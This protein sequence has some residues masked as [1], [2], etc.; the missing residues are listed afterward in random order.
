MSIIGTQSTSLSANFDDWGK[1]YVSAHQP[2]KD[3]KSNIKQ[4]RQAWRSTK[5]IHLW[6]A[7]RLTASSGHY[8][9]SRRKSAWVQHDPFGRNIQSVFWELSCEGR[10]FLLNHLDMKTDLKVNSAGF[11]PETPKEF[12]VGFSSSA[13]TPSSSSISQHT[14]LWASTKKQA[15]RFILLIDNIVEGAYWI[16]DAW[17]LCWLF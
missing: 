14:R 2:T 3:M 4:S 5:L 1:L 10:N 12:K 7:H 16:S 13:I 11:V 8:T 6:P 9:N 15:L 17:C